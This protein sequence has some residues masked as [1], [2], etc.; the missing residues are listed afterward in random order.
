M[1]EETA[2]MARSFGY[3]PRSIACQIL[4]ISPGGNVPEF[5][6]KYRIRHLD[7]SFNGG[8]AKRYFHEQDCYLAA[9]A[10]KNQVAL[11]LTGE[12]GKPALWGA[13][14]NPDL[15]G[16]KLHQKI[17]SLQARINDLETWARDNGYQS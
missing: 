6:D 5:A 3:V 15:N 4:G 16:G 13:A 2:E 12:N 7:F 9:N 1:F 17:N 8:H 14:A 10:R 11:P